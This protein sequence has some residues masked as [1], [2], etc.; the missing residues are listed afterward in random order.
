MLEA[1]FGACPTEPGGTIVLDGRPARFGEPAEAI[2]A[3][4]ALVTEDRKSLGLFTKMTVAENITIRRLDALTR[5]GLVDRG[6]EARAVRE[7][8]ERL[9][10]KT[11]GGGAPI[12]SLSGGNQQKCI[13]ARWLLINPKLL[14]LDEPTRGIDVGAK[15]EIYA[16]IRQLAGQGMAVLMT[17][18]ELPELLT[19]SDRILVLC[20]GRLTAE[21]SEGRRQRGGHHA[22]GD[23]VPRPR[24]W[25]NDRGWRGFL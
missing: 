9:S 16:L 3:G 23:A 17:S 21:F 10:I 20:E 22:R 14:L 13:I 6:A 7:S 15:A 11:D 24:G 8:I 18:S 25:M 2:A 1:L 4:V 5:G 12:L 19:V